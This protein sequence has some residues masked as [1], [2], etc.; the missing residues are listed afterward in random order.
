MTSEQ[1]KELTEIAKESKGVS[2]LTF[3]YRFYPMVA[4]AKEFISEKKYGNTHFVY[5]GYVQDWCLNKS[6][7]SWRMDPDK[8]GP[9][10]AI[11]DIGS[12]W[13]DTVQNILGKKIVKVFADL[14]T[15][16]PFREKSINAVETFSKNQD[17]E[18]E[19]IEITTEDYGSVLIHFEDGTQGV[20]TVS[21]VSAGRKNKF[22]FDI[23]LEKGSI[24]WDQEMPNRLWI[25]K[26]DEPNQELMKDP[27]LL[28]ANAASLAHYP[29][30]HQEGWPDGMKNL[31]LDFYEE[32]IVKKEGRPS[33]GKSTFATIEDGHYIMQLIDAILESH[34]TKQW[35]KITEEVIK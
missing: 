11:A 8:N 17:E 26:R 22:H 25:G 5:G 14:K 20:F 19:I 12:H 6:D 3:N 2:G 30:G 32:V 1:S 13:C 21:Q 33:K 9:S 34:R 18:K 31:L 7:Y 23:A 10:R 16:Y 15:V 28:S 24:A 29:G 35:V 4:Q 27:S